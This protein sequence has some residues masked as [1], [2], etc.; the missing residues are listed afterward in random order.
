LECQHE[1]FGQ[2]YAAD[3][4]VILAQ[5]IDSGKLTR[6]DVLASIAATDAA[7]RAEHA[8]I[9]TAVEATNG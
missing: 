5:M 8:A 4:E 3:A 6:A 9:Q 2:H 1:Q 7:E